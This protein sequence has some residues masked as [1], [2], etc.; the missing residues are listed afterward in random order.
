ML[1]KILIGRAIVNNYDCLRLHSYIR[2]RKEKKKV[3]LTDCLNMENYFFPFWTFK[4]LSML[5]EGIAVFSN[6]SKKFNILIEDLNNINALDNQIINI[7][8]NKKIF[9]NIES[10]L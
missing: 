4:Y 3:L 2:F 10:F 1:K 9:E 5:K 6:R 7:L 8:N